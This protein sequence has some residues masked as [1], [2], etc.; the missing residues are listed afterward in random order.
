MMFRNIQVERRLEERA[1][2]LF[3]FF[4]YLCLLIIDK[5]MRK[6]ISFINISLLFLCVPIFFALTGCEKENQPQEIIIKDSIFVK[7]TIFLKDTINHYDTTIVHD[8]TIRKDTIIIHD[9]LF[10]HPIKILHIG[11][12]YS[13]DMM[14]YVQYLLKDL[15]P[16]AD[17]TIGVLYNAGASLQRYDE[18]LIPN[19][20]CYAFYLWKNG[21]YVRYK[22]NSLSIID[23]LSMENWDIVTLQQQSNRSKDYST[24][25]PYLNNVIK[26]IEP[27][28]NDG[29]ELGFILTTPEYIA[30][31][32]LSKYESSIVGYNGQVSA[33]KNVLNDSKCSFIIPVGTAVQNLRTIE[34]FRYYGNG[35][36]MMNISSSGADHLQTGIGMLAEGY[37]Y[38]LWLGNKI[39]LN[40]DLSKSHYYPKEG[41]SKVPHGEMQGITLENC[42]LA[43]KAAVYAIK[44][45]FEITN[46]ANEI[47]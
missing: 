34:S 24:Y 3:Y 25:Q 4:P 9:T 33:A 15:L 47:E 19:N 32:K 2:P 11:N 18:D 26:Q 40:L 5:T 37:A 23:I 29:C 16:N 44:S 28:F 31:N 43:K 20:T 45:P 21:E 38:M 35:E 13:L 8:T 27:F 1:A 41:D 39:G 12:S 46:M 7:D 22:T 6:V 17:V 30:R 36:G 10:V 42:I 14:Q